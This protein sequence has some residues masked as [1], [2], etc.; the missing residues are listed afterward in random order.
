[1]LTGLAHQG[2][3]VLPLKGDRRAFRIMLIVG[4]GRVRRLDDPAK[5]ALQPIEPLQGGCPFRG[6]PLMRARLPSHPSWVPGGGRA[7]FPGPGV[8]AATGS[9]LAQYLHLVA[10]TGMS[11]DWHWG[12]VLAG[13]GSPKT[14]WP[15]RF[16]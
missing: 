11:V 3:H 1:M 13:G 4:P 10:A 7:V 9:S 2:R 8:Q 6:Q 12:H 5:F 16:I 15:R 14:A